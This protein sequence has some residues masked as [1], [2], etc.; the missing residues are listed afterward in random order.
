MRIASSSMLFVCSTVFAL[1]LPPVE[2]ISDA[3][4]IGRQ[5]LLDV[6]RRFT[7]RYVLWLQ[8]Q[9]FEYNPAM[10]CFQVNRAPDKEFSLYGNTLP[11]PAFV[12][13]TSA[14]PSQRLQ[15]MSIPLVLSGRMS[16]ARHTPCNTQTN[17]N[18]YCR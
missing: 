8:V 7:S 10:R 14:L 2:M 15:S 11:L 1:V 12:C 3:L 17:A 18:R 9:V 16:G 4:L 6:A 5:S 13:C